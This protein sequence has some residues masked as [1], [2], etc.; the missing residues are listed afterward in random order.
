MARAAMPWFYRLGG[1]GS[2]ESKSTVDKEN[3]VIDE[4]RR[5]QEI[6]LGRIRGEEPF[7]AAVTRP[8]ATA[9]R[10]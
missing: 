6:L 9:F 1:I 2:K 3:P 4:V 5:D 10:G 7:D 8:R